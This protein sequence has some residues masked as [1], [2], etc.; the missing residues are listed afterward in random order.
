MPVLKYLADTNAISDYFRTGTPVK[1]WFLTHRG[2]IGVSTFTLAEIRR[3]IELK[4]N[5]KT[6]FAL[7]R[8]FDFVLEDYR[9]A[10]YAFDEAAAAEWGR[11]MAEAK[12]KPIPYDDSLIGAIA[13][14]NG[15]TV[16]TRNEKHFP[17]CK[18]VNPWRE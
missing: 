8:I 2:E 14:S 3:G 5:T 7:E 1:A 10:I 13:R 6:R 17:G 18:T 15:L 12:H 9:E 16:V 4:G 11:M